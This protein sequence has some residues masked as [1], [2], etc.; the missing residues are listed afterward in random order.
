MARVAQLVRATAYHEAGH[1]VARLALGLS[2]GRVS[3]V[4]DAESNGHCVYALSR[5][6]HPD[7]ANGQR[8]EAAVHR[9]IVAALAGESA[10]YVLRG[11]HNWGGASHDRRVAA[12][13]AAYV[14]GDGEEEAA[15]LKWL[16]IKARNL[17]RGRWRAVEAVAALLLDTK[18]ASRAQVTATIQGA[19]QLSGTPATG[20]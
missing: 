10:E 14:S 6:F 3:I 17:V 4:S 12:D 16:D 18:E 11:R 5:T 20:N 19:L 13:L 7:L 1:A 15:L 8:M 2:L 9:H